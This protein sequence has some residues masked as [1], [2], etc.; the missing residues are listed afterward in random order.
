GTTFT[1]LYP[2]AANKTVTL[3]GLTLNGLFTL[4]NLPAA[5]VGLGGGGYGLQ[6][7][8]TTTL[9]NNQVIQVTTAT[10]SNV[11]QGLTL[12]GKVTDVPTA[13]TGTDAGDVI[14]SAGHGYANGAL[15]EFTSLT[16]GSG[17]ATNTPYYV[18]NATANSF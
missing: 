5:T 10:A 16:G 8:G 14:V 17:L 9:I 12:S 1:P 18:V 13:V 11:V 6:V 4:S 7:L 3:S 15:L 2:L